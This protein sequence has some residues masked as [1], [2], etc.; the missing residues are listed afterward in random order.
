MYF[1]FEMHI[2]HF[3]HQWKPLQAVPLSMA[4]LEQLLEVLA[5]PLF[6]VRS[7][8][9]ISVS[10]RMTRNK[11]P[12]V[13]RDC[14]S[15]NVVSHFLK[16]GESGS[17]F[18]HTGWRVCKLVISGLKWEVCTGFILLKFDWDRFAIVCFTPFCS[19]SLAAGG[20]Y[21]LSS[22]NTSSTYYAT[23]LVRNTVA[24]DSTLNLVTPKTWCSPGKCCWTLQ[25]IPVRMNWP[26]CCTRQHWSRLR[27]HRWKDLIILYQNIKTNWFEQM[28]SSQR[29]IF[30]LPTSI[31]LEELPVHFAQRI[32]MLEASNTRKFQPV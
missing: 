26:G 4:R 25:P 5:K 8:S 12:K 13:N 14:H 16:C 27:V 9:F 17:N 23:D 6:V 18:H 24:H 22:E 1:K 7:Q 28:L 3:V 2:P 29:K 11:F 19:R 15:D 21:H 30:L 32:K 10:V 20:D 31:C